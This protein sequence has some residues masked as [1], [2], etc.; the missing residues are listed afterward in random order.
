[1]RDN[2]IRMRDGSDHFCI[3]GFVFESGD[4]I[5][6]GAP[7]RRILS[8]IAVRLLVATTQQFALGFDTCLLYTSRCV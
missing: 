1:M 6:I 8:Q 5:A 2:L 4:E 3:G 7:K